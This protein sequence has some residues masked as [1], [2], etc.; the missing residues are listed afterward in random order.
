MG[1]RDMNHGRWGVVAQAQQ[2]QVQGAAHGC[3]A[4]TE[5]HAAGSEVVAQ[6]T[7]IQSSE[8]ALL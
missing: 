4:L 8:L 2:V 5:A 1:S 7:S 3:S 6:C